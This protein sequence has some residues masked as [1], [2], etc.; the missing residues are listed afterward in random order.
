MNDGSEPSMTSCN[1]AGWPHIISIVS[2]AAMHTPLPKRGHYPALRVDR[3][4]SVLHPKRGHRLRIHG[5]GYH[6]W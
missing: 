3:I 1:F 5:W 6:E 2:T 4:L